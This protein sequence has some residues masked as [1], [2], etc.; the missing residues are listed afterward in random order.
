MRLDFRD[1]RWTSERSQI[2]AE[3][4][5]SWVKTAEAAADPYRNAS[6]A[7]RER[8][9]GGGQAAGSSSGLRPLTALV[10]K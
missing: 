2:R 9:G 10:V 6:L 4:L 8:W 7:D 3:T 5:P 1:L